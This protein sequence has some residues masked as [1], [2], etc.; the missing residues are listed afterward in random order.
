[1]GYTRK[2]HEKTLEDWWRLFVCLFVCLFACV[3]VCACLVGQR[4]IQQQMELGS[5]PF[6]SNPHCK[7]C[8]RNKETAPMHSPASEDVCHTFST[9]A[10]NQL[11]HLPAKASKCWRM[12]D[13]WGRLI[14]N[15]FVALHTCRYYN[16]IS[17][18]LWLQPWSQGSCLWRWRVHAENLKPLGSQRRS[19][20]LLSRPQ[21]QKSAD[22]TRAQVAIWF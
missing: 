13:H 4:M 9:R 1:M 11:W 21:M 6:Q 14:W 19:L 18:G 16:S 3:C 12:L 15:L 20:C 17:E 2:K 8:D 5:W 10:R 7:M 22:F